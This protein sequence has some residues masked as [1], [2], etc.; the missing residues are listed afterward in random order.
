M[1]A[2][3][4]RFNPPAIAVTIF[5]VIATFAY[6]IHGLKSRELDER[7]DQ[8]VKCTPS[9]TQTPPPPPPQQTPPPPPPPCPPPPSP[10]ALSPPP[11]PKKPPTHC[12]PLPPTPPSIIY[13][14]GPPGSLYPID[15]NFG[16]AS[17][18]FQVGYLALLSGFMLLLAF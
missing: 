10:P 7:G 11:T 15:Q 6:P 18:N 1:S 9:C 2:K 16:G 13:T 14:T 5:L 3:T 8:G 12:C 4:T 17:R